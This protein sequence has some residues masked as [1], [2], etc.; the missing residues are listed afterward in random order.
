MILPVG[1]AF[2]ESAARSFCE[3]S[4]IRLVEGRGAEELHAA[5]L[6][7]GARII[8]ERHWAS[9]VAGGAAL[10]WAIGYAVSRRRAERP[11]FLD[12]FPFADPGT[13][14]YGFLLSS[15]F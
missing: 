15:K 12:F 5:T 11:P 9:D 2:T 10:G 8:Q 13:R 4:S 3:L 1:L 14:T 7:G 6:V